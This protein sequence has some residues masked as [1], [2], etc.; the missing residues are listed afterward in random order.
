MTFLG[1]FALAV[2]LSLDSLGVGA[3]Y[4]LRRIRVPF[5]LY[6]VVALCTGTLMAL[7]MV[8]GSRLAAFLP[9]A[10]ARRAGG[11]VL[12]GVG[13]WQLY[14]GWQGYRRRL[15]PSDSGGDPAA[16]RQV[17]RLA[18]R[19]LGLVIQILVEPAA[20][21]VDGSGRIETPEAFALGLALGLDSLGAGFGASMAGY[22]LTVVPVVALFCA[23]FLALG[24][25]A[26]RRPAAGLLS[27]RA[28]F[29]PGTLLILLGILRLS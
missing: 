13:V 16:P 9:P 3:A 17:L 1:M 18:L 7:S 29:L 4:G 27:R 20:A 11:V 24:L 28:F 5:S 22:N 2:A 15:V 10:A 23:L 8:L 25:G 6:V 26:A 14:Q 12:M 21:D 19:S